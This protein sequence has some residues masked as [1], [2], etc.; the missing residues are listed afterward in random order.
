MKSALLRLQCDAQI[1][2]RSGMDLLRMHRVTRCLHISR[3]QQVEVLVCQFER[4]Q[5]F[6]DIVEGVVVG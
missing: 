5:Q 1:V 2:E 6:L 3:V 4:I